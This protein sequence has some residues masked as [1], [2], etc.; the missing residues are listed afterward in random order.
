VFYRKGASNFSAFD[1]EAGG[2]MLRAG[3]C[4]GE[5]NDRYLNI[6]AVRWRSGEG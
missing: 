1:F 3:Y 2:A 6:G 4:G 5:E